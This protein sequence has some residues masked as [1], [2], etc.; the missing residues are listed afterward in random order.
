MAK[1]TFKVK[2]PPGKVPDRYKEE[3]NAEQLA[4]V[5]H[6]RGPAL[7]IAGAGSGKTRALT[8]RVAY[9]IDRGAP[10]ESIVLVTFTKKAA[11]EMTKRADY[12][13]GGRAKGILAGTFH[14]LCNLFLRRYAP[15]VGYTRNYTILDPGDQR[16]LMKL[17]ISTVI[18]KDQRKR[19]PNAGQFAEIYSK[20]INLEAKVGEVVAQH[21]PWYADEVPTIKQ[22]LGKYHQRKRDN[23]VMD[24]DDMLV[25]FVN[26]LRGTGAGKKIRKGV[27]HLLVDEFQDVNAI[28]ADIVEELGA[29]AESLVVV[30]DDAQAIYGTVGG[31]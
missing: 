9:L 6:D 10:P 23:N 25:N 21:F 8:Y 28:Q 31:R 27:R 26:L 13:S 30:G 12:V 14:H 4:V 3:L 1:K 7:L 19:F 16:E 22:V 24:F 2:R 11:E 5:T 29:G 15:E 17:V 18:P 20:S